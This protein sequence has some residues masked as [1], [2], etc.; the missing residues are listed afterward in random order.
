MK[1]RINPS[2]K[3]IKERKV[4]DD[5]LLKRIAHKSPQYWF[6][7]NLQKW[8]GIEGLPEDLG[9]CWICW[10]LITNQGL[11]EWRKPPFSEIKRHPSVC[12]LCNYDRWSGRIW[13]PKRYVL[14]TQVGNPSRRDNKCLF[15]SG[16][17]PD[18]NYLLFR[19]SRIKSK[20]R[21]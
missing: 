9:V 13:Y 12:P 8:G 18:A 20:K 4:V 19:F 14:L 10:V 16:K 21:G 15:Y 1:K 3:K 7:K 6:R 2:R 11:K 5:D 17:N